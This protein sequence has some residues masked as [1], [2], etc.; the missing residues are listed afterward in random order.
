MSNCCDV[1]EGYSRGKAGA[2]HPR[3]R[4]DESVHGVKQLLRQIGEFVQFELDARW[5]GQSSD[6]ANRGDARPMYLTSL[7]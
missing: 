6:E 7:V 5:S 1:N 4:S 2:E 3:I